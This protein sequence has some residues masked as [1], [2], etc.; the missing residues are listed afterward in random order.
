MQ[1]SVEKEPERLVFSEG[2][3]KYIYVNGWLADMGDG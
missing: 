1:E 3:L 2:T